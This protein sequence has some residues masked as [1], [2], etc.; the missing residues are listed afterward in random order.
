MA[1]GECNTRELSQ[2]RDE[3]VLKFRIRSLSRGLLLPKVMPVATTDQGGGHVAHGQPG[4]GSLSGVEVDRSSWPAHLCAHPAGIDGVAQDLRPASRQRKSQ[5][6]HIQLAFGVR[7]GRIPGPRRPI[8]VAQRALSTAVQ[9][10][11]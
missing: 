8:K 4:L 10:P 6:H 2:S 7:P 9:A 1:F 3:F 5:R 11:Y